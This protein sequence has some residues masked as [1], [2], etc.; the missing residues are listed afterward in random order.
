MVHSLYLDQRFDGMYVILGDLHVANAEIE[1]AKD[2]EKARLIAVR[3]SHF[4]RVTGFYKDFERL[5]TPYVRMH[6]KAPWF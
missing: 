3:R 1:Y 2:N 6:Q 4:D 5:L